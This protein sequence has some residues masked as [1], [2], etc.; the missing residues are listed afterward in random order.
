M[1]TIGAEAPGGLGLCA[2]GHRVV[3]IFHLRG[4]GGQQ[5]LRLQNNSGSVH[6]VLLS[7][8][9]RDELE[10]KIGEK[11]CPEKASWGPAQLE[12]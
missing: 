12:F 10:Q 9:F 3:N 2:Q 7:R 1:N 5:R 11:V 8:C 6:Q 4:W